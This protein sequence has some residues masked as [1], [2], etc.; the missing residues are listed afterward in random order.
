M[1][2]VIGVSGHPGAGKTSLILGLVQ[3]LEGAAPIHMDSYER[4]TRR[5]IEAIDRWMKE[6]ADIDAFEFGELD[7]D[8][9]RL[10]QGLTVEDRFSR[11]PVTSRKYVLFETQF[12][13]AHRKTGR[14]IDLQIWIDVAPDVALARN[15]KA[16]LAGFLREPEPAQLAARVRWLDGYLDNYLATVHALLAMQR[17]RVARD[18]DLRLDGSVPLPAMIEAARAGILRRLP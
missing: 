12:G 9:L 10:K 15:V 4:V 13:R 8:L 18:A 14:H 6:G 3:A 16:L 7:A 2:H 11:R 5:P 1:N 17:E